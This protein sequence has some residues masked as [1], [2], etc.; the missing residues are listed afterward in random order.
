MNCGAEFVIVLGFNFNAQS[1]AGLA[2]T[3]AGQPS[4]AAVFLHTQFLRSQHLWLFCPA[5]SCLPMGSAGL[6]IFRS[7]PDAHRGP[8]SGGLVRRNAV[9]LPLS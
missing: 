4:L 5:V 2:A 6:L 3:C 7:F 8:S 1:H 9:W